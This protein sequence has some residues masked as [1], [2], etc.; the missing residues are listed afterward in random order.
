MNAATHAG[1]LGI[2]TLGLPGT[3]VEGVDLAALASAA[4]R[5]SSKQMRNLSWHASVCGT[6]SATRS[7]PLQP[8]V[9]PYFK[10]LSRVTYVLLFRDGVGGAA[11]SNGNESLGSKTGNERFAENN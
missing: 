10:T 4:N 1:V 3:G 7:H 8:A 5:S 6:P 11:P 2:G 9:L